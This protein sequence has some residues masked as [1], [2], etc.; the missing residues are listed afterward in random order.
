MESTNIPSMLDIH[1]IQLLPEREDGVKF[2]AHRGFPLATVPP[3]SWRHATL[4][5][6]KNKLRVNCDN[7]DAIDRLAGMKRAVSTHLCDMPC[8]FY[9]DDAAQMYDQVAMYRYAL[10]N[11]TE[12][13]CF[14]KEETPQLVKDFITAYVNANPLKEPL[15]QFPAMVYV[16]LNNKAESFFWAFSA[17]LSGDATQIEKI[18]VKAFA[19]YTN[20]AYATFVEPPV[21]DF[22]CSRFEAPFS[23]TDGSMRFK[24]LL[25]EVADT[26]KDYYLSE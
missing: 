19:D 10:L 22:V 7:I 2:S 4:D 13:Y 20:A 6:L 26:V 23:Y 25:D 21:N 17:P 24:D 18:S 5:Y 15:R 16:S 1:V 9:K 11:L 14:A 12:L 8:L 3:L